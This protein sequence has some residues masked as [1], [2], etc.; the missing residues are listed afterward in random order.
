MS[1]LGPFH[2]TQDSGHFGWYIKWNGPFR[3]GPTGILGTSFEGSPL[4]PI[5]SFWAVGPRGPFPF[6][7]I[8]VS[9][10]A[11][12]YPAYK[13]NNQTHGGLGRVQPECTV[14]LGKWNFRRFKWEFC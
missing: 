3:F 14:P 13:N 7:K 12:L 10:T 8:I 11:L 4:R 2:S 6:G 9:S 5:W 1:S